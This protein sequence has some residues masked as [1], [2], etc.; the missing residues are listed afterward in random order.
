MA[1]RRQGGLAGRRQE[2][3]GPKNDQKSSKIE[4]KNI[5]ADAQPR[6]YKIL[7]PTHSQAPLPTHSQGYTKFSCR[8]PERETM[9][10]YGIMGVSP[11]ARLWP[12]GSVRTPK[13][14]FTKI[15]KNKKTKLPLTTYHL[16]FNPHSRRRAKRGGGYCTVYC[17]AYLIM[18]I[19][20]VGPCFF[21][22]HHFH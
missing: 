17:I 16:P 19:G 9:R 8:R 2:D 14:P 15:K 18:C 12:G 4:L 13:L 10:K 20:D 1:G 5:P 11:R 22:E 21:T 6:I 7:L 3:F